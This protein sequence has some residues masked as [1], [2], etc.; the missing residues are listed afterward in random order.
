MHAVNNLKILPEI[1]PS[2]T[3]IIILCF[4][5]PIIAAFLL[6][7]K[8]VSFSKLVS[9]CGFI[10]FMFG[11]HVHEKA[12][13]PYVNLLFLF[14]T[15][16]S[17]INAAIFVNIVNLIPLLIQPKEKSL[18]LIMCL[19]WIAVWNYID[20]AKRQKMRKAQENFIKQVSFANAR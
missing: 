5:V 4:L 15:E 9:V 18:S 3:I 14:E 8:Q 19:I 17:C 7:K 16:I 11:F 2:T 10:F 6:T 1:L 13:V 20:K 12:I